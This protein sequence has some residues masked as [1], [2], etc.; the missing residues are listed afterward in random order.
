MRTDLFDYDLPPE[1][2]AQE[3]PARRGDSRLMLVDRA[4]GAV[5]HHVF[6]DLPGLLSPGDLLVLNRTRVRRA[7]LG[8]RKVGTGANIELL[9]L[10]PLEGRRWEALVR[11]GRRLAP[12]SRVDA[13]GMRFE[14]VERRDGGT[15]VLLSDRDAEAVEAALLEH[16]EM[17]TPPYIKRRLSDPERYQTVYARE[18]GSAAAPTAGM[19]LTLPML[20]R[21]EEMG[22]EKT[23]V[24]LEIGLATFRPIAEP[25][26][27]DHRI[28]SEHV[29]VG[30]D[31]CDAVSATRLARGRVV[32]VGTTSARAL[33]TAAVGG[34]ELEPYDG[35]TDLY[36][37]PGYD[38][39]A[40]DVLLT[41]FHLPRSTLLVLVSAIGG[42][43]LISRAYREAVAERYRFYSFGDAMLII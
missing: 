25:I 9:L 1:L 41:N 12:G 10:R 42:H 18:L 19:H 22:V 23:G 17:P 39:R 40:V 29:H 33:E 4:N 24:C 11:P 28:H 2:I 16:G 35:E 43:E 34:G 32:A 31:A 26:V 13:G 37:Y 20:R 7:R 8:G 36:I 30:R 38:W 3:P 5:S 14:L 21:L 15:V 27:E 6:D